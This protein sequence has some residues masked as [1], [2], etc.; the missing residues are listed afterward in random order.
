MKLFDTEYRIEIYNEGNG[1][2]Q[3][4]VSDFLSKEDAIG[5]LEAY[6]QLYDKSVY[7]LCELTISVKVLDI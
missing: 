5:T 3:E 6:R 2:W 7:R 4:H 1:E